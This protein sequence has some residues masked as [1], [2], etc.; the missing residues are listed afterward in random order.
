[1]CI[2][3]WKKIGIEIKGIKTIIIVLSFLTIVGGGLF[4]WYEWRPNQIKQRCSAEARFDTRATLEFDDIKRQE[5]IN[6]YYEDCLMRFGL[7]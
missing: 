6:R 2:L 3:G 5:F 1:M 4:Y 7:K